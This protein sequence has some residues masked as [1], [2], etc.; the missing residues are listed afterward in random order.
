MEIDLVDLLFS[1]FK[2]IIVQGKAPVVLK[3]I[4]SN[5]THE[6]DEIA[7]KISIVQVMTCM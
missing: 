2:F 3:N 5:N 4:N 6:R 7:Q 1:I